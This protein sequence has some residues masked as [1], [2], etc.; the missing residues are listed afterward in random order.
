MGSSVLE[1]GF[2]VKL[3][4]LS[5]Y[6]AMERGEDWFTSASF[7]TTLLEQQKSVYILRS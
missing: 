6:P 7:H 3:P 2:D 5:R 1:A 4:E